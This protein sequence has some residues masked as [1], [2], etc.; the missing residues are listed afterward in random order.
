MIDELADVFDF[1]KIV[2]YFEKNKKNV[3]FFQ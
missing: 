1:E 3:Y 2:R